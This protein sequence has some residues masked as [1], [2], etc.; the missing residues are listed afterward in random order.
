[1][2]SDVLQNHA[3][4]LLVSLPLA[5]VGDT[6]ISPHNIQACIC[7]PHEMARRITSPRKMWLSTILLTLT[8]GEHQSL[9]GDPSP[10]HPTA[11]SMPQITE[12]KVPLGT[13]CDAHTE[14]HLYRSCLELSQIITSTSGSFSIIHIL[15]RNKILQI[16][17]ILHNFLFP[18]KRVEQYISHLPRLMKS[19]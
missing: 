15:L 16:E 3:G 18:F 9:P 12:P 10:C 1:M 5:G 2:T 19:T 8:R 6:P 14:P 13:W 17:S 11:S 7:H 4:P